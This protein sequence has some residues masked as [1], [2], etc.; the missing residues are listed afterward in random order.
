VYLSHQARY[1]APDS[2][3]VGDLYDP[4]KAGGL[5]DITQGTNGGCGNLLCQAGP[6]WDGPT[7]LGTPNGVAAL[8]NSP[9][10]DIAGQV[11]DASTGAPLAG[12]SVS[13]PQGYQV[14]TDSSGRYDLRVI[15]GSYDV[16]ARE[17]GYAPAT[18]AGVQASDGQTTTVNFALTP[19][20]SST[21]SGTVTDGSGQGWPLYAKITIDGYPNGPVYT[22]P[23]TGRYTVKL[24]QQ[25]SYT[26]HV[27]PVYEPGYV[28]QTLQLAVGATDTIRQDFSLAID[29]TAC[30][31]PGYGRDGLSE[32]FT[33]WTGASAKDG[34]TVAGSSH[35]W[36]FDNPGYRTPPV[37]PDGQFAIADSS[38]YGPGR[39]DTTLTSPVADLS[40]QAAPGLSFDSAYYAA[41]GETAA[42]DLSVDGGT[43]WAMVWRRDTSNALGH[44]GL[45]LPQAAHQASVRVRFHYTG[46]NAWWWGVDNIFL[47][48]RTCVPISG[49]L[50]EGT[51]SDTTGPPVVGALISSDDRPPEFAVSVATPDDANLPDGFYWLFSTLTGPHPFTASHTGDNPFTTSV[52]IAPG[53][54]TRQDWTLTRSG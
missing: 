12:A 8:S 28:A 46:N 16:T 41:K 53:Q 39:M 23:V 19:V 15:A 30:D 29:T 25:A 48:T 18:Q 5:F 50:L 6:G 45:A 43:T 34:W 47:G 42:V 17:F 3:P 37:T 20:P 27:A 14:R 38:F 54:I 40:G 2:Y 13:T 21:V 4:A 36:R 11:T 10:G 51:I 49:G 33:G 1:A 22:D 26:L 52:N 35:G 31:T 24:A 7:G 32:E 9:H 44:V